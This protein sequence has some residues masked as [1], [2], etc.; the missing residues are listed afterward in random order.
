M[1]MWMRVQRGGVAGW[2]ARRERERERAAHGGQTWQPESSCTALHS[3][4]SLHPLAFAVNS[5]DACPCPCPLLVSPL[6][7]PVARATLP[8]YPPPYIVVL[9]T[10][11]PTH[12]HCTKSNPL[13]HRPGQSQPAS[14]GPEYMSA[15]PCMPHWPALPLPTLSILSRP[16]AS[17]DAN[18]GY[19]FHPQRCRS[20]SL[21][22][23]QK[24]RHPVVSSQ[25]PVNK[26]GENP[27]SCTT[28]LGACSPDPPTT[29]QNCPRCPCRPPSPARPSSAHTACTHIVLG[30]RL[31]TAS[32]P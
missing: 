4:P 24:F 25:H 9:P 27:I 28:C 10:Y 22:S 19:L 13:F 6:T 29:R 7:C 23:V 30:L 17:L 5:P 18:L 1:R 8:T 14:E 21:C 12:R 31:Q 2:H 3:A 32:V 26:Q 20:L 11:P 15:I 16:R